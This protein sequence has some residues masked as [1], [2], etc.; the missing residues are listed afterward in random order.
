MPLYEYFCETCQKEVTVVMSISEHAKGAATCPQC[1]GK[2]MRQ[3]V[4]TVFT[5]TSKKS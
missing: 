1:G 4:S 5:Q 3:L 2:Q